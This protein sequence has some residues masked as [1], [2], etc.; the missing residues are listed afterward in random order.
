MCLVINYVM[1]M[2][3]FVSTY[4]S[5]GIVPDSKQLPHP[6]LNEEHL[7]ASMLHTFGIIFECWKAS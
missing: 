1:I 5:Q 7:P 2:S 6:L 4:L 3:E